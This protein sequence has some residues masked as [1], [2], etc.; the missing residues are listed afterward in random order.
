M[1]GNLPH[2][3]GS[4]RLNTSRNPLNTAP[5]EALFVLSGIS[6]YVGAVIAVR[7]FEQLAP[8]PSAWFRVIGA[9]FWLLLFSATNLRREGRFTREQLK[10]AALFGVATAFMN[11]TFYLAI[12][13]LDLGKGVAIEFIGPITVAALTTRTKRNALALALAAAGVV[14]L[15]GIEIDSEPL[16]LL[17]IFLAAFCWAIYIVLGARVA[18]YDRGVAGL[19]IGLAIGAIVLTP[20]GLPQS[21]PAWSDPTLL[22]W[23]LLIG[24]F[25]NAVAYGIDQ[26]TLRRIPVRRF[27]VLLALLPVT[28]TVFGFFFLDQTPSTLDVIGIALVLTGVIVQQRDTL[29][30]VEPLRD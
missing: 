9:A 8:A 4:V 18:Q 30:A 23:C 19:G 17:F 11:L 1:A 28:A 2:R 22:G 25:S 14:V 27:S 29:T 5:P 15:S 10:A 13:R 24:L 26:Y 7:L 20:I 16:G 21:G 3:P 12:N 6:Q